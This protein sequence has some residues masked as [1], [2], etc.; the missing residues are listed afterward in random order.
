MKR[1][2]GIG[3]DFISETGLYLMG[4]LPV[5]GNILSPFKRNRKPYICLLPF[6]I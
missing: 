2:A 6:A 4:S 1:D 5:V 3:G